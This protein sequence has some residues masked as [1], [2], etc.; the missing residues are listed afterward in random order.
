MNTP[1]RQD[2]P[3]YR[4]APTWSSRG[5]GGPAPEAPSAIASSQAYATAL[6]FHR[7]RA[8]PAEPGYCLYW[9]TA[10]HFNSRVIGG[11]SHFVMGRHTACDA[12]L[13]GDGTIALRH[14]LLRSAVLN[15]GCPRLSI[16]DLETDTGFIP[17]DGSLQRSICAAGPLALRVG[18]YSV[19]AL[20]SGVD[21]PDALSTRIAGRA[22]V[23]VSSRAELAV[24]RVTL[25]PR[26]LVLADRPTMHV[27]HEATQAWG[28]RRAS[29]EY[30]LAVESAS[31]R[32]SVFL[33][34]ADLDR[35]VLVGRATKCFDS[36]LRSILNVGI[37]R[38]H[39]LLL[40]D[41]LECRAYDIA[42]TQG[43]FEAGRGIRQ[44]RLE[45]DGTRLNLG[46]STGIRLAWRR[47]G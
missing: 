42:S 16:L 41:Q 27:V 12:V 14:I 21:L 4:N 20:P 25:I 2:G 46:T 13:E 26:A 28:A 29:P 30:E 19:I 34:A 18:A 32:V 36:G 22:D 11:A 44:T 37:S 1:P 10:V 23:R 7:E 43:T 3:T 8:Q 33:S 31:A 5:L 17:P 6:R 24:S 45:D 47:L 40:R 9:M 39:V 35:G 38:V 15:D